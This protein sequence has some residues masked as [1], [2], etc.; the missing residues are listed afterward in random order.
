MPP[1]VADLLFDLGDAFAWFGQVVGKIF[2]LLYMVLLAILPILGKAAIAA[3]NAAIPAIQ[4]GLAVFW[5]YVGQAASDSTEAVKPYVGEA[6]EAAQPYL[7]EV[8]N[9]AKDA[10]A[11]ILTQVEGIKSAADSVA[12]S[13]SGK[14]TLVPS[15]ATVE[16]VKEVAKSAAESVTNAVEAAKTSVEEAPGVATSTPS[17][18][19]PTAAAGS[20]LAPPS[21][22]SPPAVPEELPSVT[23]SSIQELSTS[24]STL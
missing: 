24:P 17:A 18:E 10:A 21:P 15:A 9:T 7:N 16:Q 8:G 12:T 6:S 2:E 4:K 11:P 3:F 1:V 23:S 13:I 14:V 19:A 20:V 22:P 5:D